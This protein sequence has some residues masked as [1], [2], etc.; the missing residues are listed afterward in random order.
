LRAVIVSAAGKALLLV[1]FTM[2]CAHSSATRPADAP[3][4]LAAVGA[5]RVAAIRQSLSGAEKAS[6]ASRRDALNA[7]A[8]QLD[9]DAANSSDA[10]KVRT[11][12]NAVRSLA[13]GTMAMR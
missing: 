5:G 2:A 4:D 1:S 7:L 3:D 12:Q 6:G 8:T 9:N 13:S 11:L 10:G